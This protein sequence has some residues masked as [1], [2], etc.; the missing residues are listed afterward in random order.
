MTRT[1]YRV[2][3]VFGSVIAEHVKVR[4]PDGKKSMHW[5]VP[6]CNPSDGL[7]GLSTPDLPLYGAERIASYVAG[8]SVV[9][10]EGEGATEALWSI[11]V[12]AVGTV[13][14]AGSTPG[15]DA[16]SVLLP[17]DVVTWEDYDE[18][19][20]SH[21]ERTASRLIRLGGGAHRLVWA[22]AQAKGDDAA[23]FVARGGTAATIDVMLRSATPWTVA[24]A[25]PRPIRPSY[26]RR[27]DTR[28][29]SARSH[30]VRV[31]EE[32]LGP[33]KRKMGRSLFWA[34]PFHTEKSP[35]FKVDLQEPFYRCFGCGARG[36]VFT[37]LRGMEG[38]EFKDVLR[39]L[40][41]PR[42]LGGIPR[43]GA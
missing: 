39:E 26:E 11:G 24:P 16:L 2:C 3:D 5:R 38:V 30:L 27:D 15:E 25:A 37:F 35:S 17:F 23:D 4:H 31:V 8:Q 28:V 13:T 34:C 21:M 40:A 6:G 33:P 41:P 32:K 43:L 7:M 19:G 36:D 20:Y 9:V 12:P 14:G 29:E 18:A 42:L 10:C 22:G 1:V